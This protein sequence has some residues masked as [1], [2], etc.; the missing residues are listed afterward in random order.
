MNNQN[1]NQ[2]QNQDQDQ[3]QDQ[4]YEVEMVDVNPAQQI[5]Q[6]LPIQLPAHIQQQIA[7]VQQLIQVLQQQPVAP[8][9]MHNF[10]AGNNAQQNNYPDGQPNNHNVP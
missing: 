8:I 4:A 2:E 3:D 5:L 6:N 10:F 9:N 7:L 1:Q